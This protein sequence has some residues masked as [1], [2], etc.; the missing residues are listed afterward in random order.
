VVVQAPGFE[1][2]ASTVQ[3]AAGG[4]SVV[5]AVLRLEA[6]A[7]AEP[8]TSALPSSAAAPSLR[9]EAG[10]AP[11]MT[12]EF[13]GKRGSRF[14]GLVTGGAGAWA[15]ATR[16]SP[17]PTVVFG[18]AGGAVV[19]ALGPR[20]DLR[21]GAKVAVAFLSET[22]TTDRFYSFLVDPTLMWAVVDR[23][24]LVA[25][26]GIGVQV[27]SGI[28]NDSI[29]LVPSG[30]RVTGDLAAFELRPAIGAAYSLTDTFSLSLGPALSLSPSPSSRF[31]HGSVVRV[32]IAAGVMAEL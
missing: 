1:P 24:R 28:P 7:T 3:V 20:I 19:A 15:G 11:S 6:P 9:D 13:G 22:A 25:E 29:L 5:D 14:Y 8:P 30:G 12:E 17:G 4:Q 32:E 18:A 26:L 10:T 31:E 21:L 2:F 27:L 16:G 23:W